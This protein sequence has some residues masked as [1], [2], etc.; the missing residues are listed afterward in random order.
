MKKFLAL[1]IA[2]FFVTG[3]VHAQTRAMLGDTTASAPSTKK[4]KK[5]KVRKTKAPRKK[6]KKSRKSK[7]KA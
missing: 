1:L 6:A 4:A 5:Q 7:S 3:P 2:V